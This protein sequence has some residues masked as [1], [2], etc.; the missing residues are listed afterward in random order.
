MNRKDK[1]SQIRKPWDF[2]EPKCAEVGVEV[3]FNPDK[4]DPRYEGRKVPLNEYTL[5]KK[6]CGE[7]DHKFECAEW[8]IENETH[9]VWGGLAPQE[10]NR[11]RRSRDMGLKLTRIN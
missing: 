4:D 11:I 10:R 1:M 8:A 7:C 3:F 5:A 2:E 6:I 9:G